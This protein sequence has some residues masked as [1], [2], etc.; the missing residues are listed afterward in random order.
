MRCGE[1]QPAAARNGN[2]IE[3]GGTF[4]DGFEDHWNTVELVTDAISVVGG[5]VV[6]GV[7]EQS[8]DPWRAQL[9]HSVMVSQGQQ[10]TLC[11]DARA[12]GSRFITAYV[13]SNLDDYRNLSGGQFRAD[14]TTSR[15][16][17]SHTFS[18]SQTDLR[19][20]VAFDFAQS[21]FDVQIDNIG[22]YEGDNC[23][24]P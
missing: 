8:S 18:A 24:S 6:V 2:L 16:S 14:L 4:A 10:Y 5:E 1:H 11:Y 15:Q 19:A 20:R 22:L 23:G 3:S 7:R 9:S 13:D 17:F 21:A 12:Q